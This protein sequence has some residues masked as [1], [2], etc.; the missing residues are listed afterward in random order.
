MA[1]AFDHP[2]QDHAQKIAALRQ[3]DFGPK[4]VVEP[5]AVV[6]F[7]GRNFV[8]SVATDTFECEGK[9]FMGISPQAPV[10]RAIEGR[11]PGETCSVNGRDVEIEAVY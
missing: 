11:G 1:Q 7:N 5:G 8:V 6:R 3:I 10:F 4:E 2:V 9:V